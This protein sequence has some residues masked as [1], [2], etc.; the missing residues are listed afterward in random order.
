VTR[1]VQLLQKLEGAERRERDLTLE[2][3]KLRDRV[4]ELHKA[5]Q[6][7]S[8]YG[9]MCSD[10]ALCHDKGYCPRDPTCGD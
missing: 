6:T 5:L 10:P 3:S 9:E 7:H 2:N 4:R 8:P 1:A